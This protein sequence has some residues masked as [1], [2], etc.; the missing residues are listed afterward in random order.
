MIRPIGIVLLLIRI[1][2]GLPPASA[3]ARPGP[4][5]PADYILVKTIKVPGLVAWTDTGLDVLVDQEYWFEGAGTICLQTGNEEAYCGPDGLNV[6]TLQQP[7]PEGNLG[8]LVGRIRQYVE[9][10]E[11]RISK[12]KTIREFGTAFFIGPAGPVKMPADGRLQLGPNENV[13]G[14]NDGAF[15]VLIYRRDARP[16]F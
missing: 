4:V 2:G 3:P 13:T 11:D 8:C 9:T 14:D 15:T 7:Y 12:E 1:I 16:V 10:T 6:Q 5:R